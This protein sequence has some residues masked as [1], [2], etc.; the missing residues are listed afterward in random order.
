MIESLERV[1]KRER[2][3]DMHHRALPLTAVLIASLSCSAHAADPEYRYAM[4]RVE[5]PFGIASSDAVGPDGRLYGRGDF[6]AQLHASAWTPPTGSAIDLGCYGGPQYSSEINSVNSKGW[7]VGTTDQGVKEYATLWRPNQTGGYD[8]I[9]LGSFGTD[10]ASAYGINDAKQIV[11]ITDH[12]DHSSVQAIIWQNGL[13]VLLPSLADKTTEAHAIN[14]AGVITGVSRTAEGSSRAV[15]WRD[16]TGNGDY[17][18]EEIGGGRSATAWDINDLDEAVGERLFS[19][20][21]DQHAFLWS[22]GTGIL[23]LHNSRIGVESRAYAINNQSQA[24]GICYYGDN[25]P[26]T[27]VAF[28]WT[29]AEGMLD[30]NQYIPPLTGNEVNSAHAINE[31]GQIAA[32]GGV[33][34]VFDAESF[35]LSPVHPSMTLKAIGHSGAIVAGANNA[36]RVNGATPG[37]RITFL[38]SS[39]GGGEAIPG[40]DLQENALQLDSPTIIGTATANAQ[41]VATLQRFVPS[42]AQGKTI[43]LQAVAPSGCAIS[44]LMLTTVE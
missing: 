36:L 34:N 18:I 15:I 17:V 7:A 24:V 11:G 32:D 13:M 41:G 14:Q 1:Q 12:P 26:E 2:E 27:A 44:Q 9:D 16:T 5:T 21:I 10:D 35:L 23:D 29:Q 37:A 39:K 3:E 19:S 8:I 6:G 30:L 42:A 4:F 33:H 28:L 22:E 25:G 43:L 38:W 20:G 31:A 40:C